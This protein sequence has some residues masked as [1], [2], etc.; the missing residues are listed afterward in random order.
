MLSI[1]IT[2]GI[3]VAYDYDFDDNTEQLIKNVVITE[4]I[5][6]QTGE[7]GVLFKVLTQ[8]QSSEFLADLHRLID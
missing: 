8:I 6:D 5:A 7:N 2:P 4:A 1:E 3:E